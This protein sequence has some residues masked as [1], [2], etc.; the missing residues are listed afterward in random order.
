M[1]E[2]R[3]TLESDLHVSIF[4]LDSVFCIYFNLVTNLKHN[5]LLYILFL[6]QYFKIEQACCF[7]IF[8]VLSCACANRKNMKIN[9]FKNILF[10]FSVLRSGKDQ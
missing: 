5:Y 2:L 1:K 9:F 10:I 3:R 6:C 4:A 7:R 8:V